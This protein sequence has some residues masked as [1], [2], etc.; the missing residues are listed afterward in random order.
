MSQKEIDRANEGAAERIRRTIKLANSHQPEGEQIDEKCWKGYEKKGMK[1]MFGKRYPNCVK[2][3]EVEQI[4]EKCWTGYTQKGMKKKGKRMVP[5][6]VPVSEDMTRI[7]QNGQTYSVILMWRGRTYTFQMFIPTMRRPAKQDIEREVR[8][9]YP[10]AR[11]LT[12]MPK[13]YDPTD[14]TIIIPEAYDSRNPTDKGLSLI[15]I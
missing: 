8:K 9:V 12:F 6:C 2:K 3:E 13:Q 1:T 11:V 5:N 7:N 10:D 4:D 15:H 14:P